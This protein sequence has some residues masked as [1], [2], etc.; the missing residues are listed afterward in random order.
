MRSV[1][2]AAIALLGALAASD[3]SAQS[4][5]RHGIIA[6][7]DGTGCL[8][9]QFAR[10]EQ[11]PPT[12]IFADEDFEVPQAPKVDIPG[13][14]APQPLCTLE[15]Q[16]D[17]NRSTHNPGLLTAAQ[18]RRWSVTGYDRTSPSQMYFLGLMYEYGHHLNQD[19]ARASQLYESAARKGFLPAVTRLTKI[20]CSKTLYCTSA[21]G[22]FKAANRGSKDARLELSR[23][24]R[25]GKGVYYDLVTAYMWA[26]LGMERTKGNWLVVDPVGENYLRGLE[27]YMTDTDLEEAE[28]RI[29]D[30]KNGFD[31][32]PLRCQQD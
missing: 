17:F 27:T 7:R 30:W 9:T 25:W 1:L 3:A 23:H 20:A 5:T 13:G 10:S 15:T 29:N 11:L 28:Q 22:Y 4:C 31:T 8:G 6:G 12:D 32:S 24:Y 14:P 21:R 26:W 18:Y 19:A 2:F 16:F